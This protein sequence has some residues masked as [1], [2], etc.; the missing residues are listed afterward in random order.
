MR[1][2]KVVEFD[3]WGTQ[4]KKMV[5]FVNAHKIKQEDIVKIMW[6][7]NNWLQLFYYA[8]EE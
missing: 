1:I 2:L 8:E 7:P 3:G 5:E 6:A 4:Q